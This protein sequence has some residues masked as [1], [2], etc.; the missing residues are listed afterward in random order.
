L[1]CWINR[2]VSTNWDMTEVERDWKEKI[3]SQ[4]GLVNKLFIPN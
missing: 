4:N 3:V 2:Y 1:I